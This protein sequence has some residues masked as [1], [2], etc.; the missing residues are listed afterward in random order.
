MLSTHSMNTLLMEASQR[1]DDVCT[2]EM[3]ER[4]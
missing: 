4:K 2:L 3:E 1:S